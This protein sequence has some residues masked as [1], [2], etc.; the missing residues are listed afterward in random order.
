MKARPWDG[1]MSPLGLVRPRVR[2][3][4]RWKRRRQR[5]VP[6]MRTL[7]AVSRNIW[8]SSWIH[9][10]RRGLLGIIIKVCIHHTEV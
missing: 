1:G 10:H 4:A 6:A 3:R 8:A 2:H 9:R 7:T 5:R